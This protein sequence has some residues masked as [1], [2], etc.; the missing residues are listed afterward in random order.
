MKWSI[1]LLNSIRPVVVGFALLGGLPLAVQANQACNTLV[2]QSSNIRAM[3]DV[4]GVATVPAGETWR[5]DGLSYLIM[6]L[7]RDTVQSAR[8]Q[9]P[10]MH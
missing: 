2:D 6:K 7:S 3:L 1:M 8:H 4:N 5:V 10:L 9:P